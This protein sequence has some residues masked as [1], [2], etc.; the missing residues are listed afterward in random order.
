MHTSSVPASGAHLPLPAIHQA[1]R[2]G[3]HRSDLDRLGCSSRIAAVPTIHA[4]L[5][6]FIAWSL[7][8]GCSF[9]T[10]G[11]PG[12]EDQPSTSTDSGSSTLAGSTTTDPSTGQTSTSGTSID[13]SASTDAMPACGDGILA[14][15][16]ECDDG[17]VNDGDGCSS[18]CTREYRRVFATSQVFTGDL[19]GIIGADAKCQEAA[20]M[21]DPPGLFRAWISSGADSPA[22][23]FV[24]SEVPYVDLDG[25]QIAA[26]WNDLTD[27]MLD[28]GI[29]KT[30]TGNL[31]PESTCA[32]TYRVAWTNTSAEGQSL[33][34]ELDCE[35]WS[36]TSTQ[37]S[38]GRLG[39]PTL[40]WTDA[41]VL[42]CTCLASL[43]CVEQ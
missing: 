30:E 28:E 25:V 6:L 18:A 20:K 24:R 42:S 26:D 13:T 37:G 8:A 1:G 5:T 14:A 4:V 35:G 21:L 2:K 9:S 43:Y 23:S 31:P 19:G 7:T 32:P 3:A 12:G 40:L 39:Y 10:Y 38:S 22:A 16:E 11:L 41:A 33:A 36:S 17:N 15:P 29:Y 34:S 27:G